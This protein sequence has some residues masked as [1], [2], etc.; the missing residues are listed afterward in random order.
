VGGVGGL[1]DPVVVVVVVVGVGFFVVVVD[2]DPP[3]Q[4][5]ITPITII[6]ANI[7]ASIFFILFSFLE[8]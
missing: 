4:D 7:R 8:N 2:V 5:A 1:V 6:N 3:K